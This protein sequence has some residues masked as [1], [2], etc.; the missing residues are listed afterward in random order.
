M[1]GVELT[2]TTG[3]QLMPGP[4]S[5]FD[6][7]AYA[8]DAQIGHVTTGDKRLLAYAVDLDVAATTRDESTN[9]LQSARIVRGSVEVTTK[10]QATITYEFTNKDPKRGRTILVE[11]PRSDG[12]DLKKPE[13][14]SD[15]TATLYRFEVAVDAGKGASLPVVQEHVERQYLAVGTFDLNTILAYARQGKASQKVVDAVREAARLQAAHADAV[16]AVARLD[17]ERQTI[18]QD[19]ARIRQNMQSVSRD[20]ELYKRYTTKLNEQETRL[21]QLVGERAGAQ[22]AADAAKA[23][24]DDYVRNLSVD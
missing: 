11:Q 14:P 17:Q 6:G 12:W 22:A 10:Q 7:P 9:V 24:F 16:Q 18:D 4:M 23:A 19:Q 5:V 20:T 8:G 1:R 2:N 13:K 21:E 15:Q 3:L